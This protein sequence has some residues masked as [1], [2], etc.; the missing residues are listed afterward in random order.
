MSWIENV[1]IACRWIETL[2]WNQVSSFSSA[3]RSRKYQTTSLVDPRRD[4]AIGHRLGDDRVGDPLQRRIGSHFRRN[5]RPQP[6]DRQPLV[7]DEAP[8]VF[9]AQHA[10]QFVAVAGGQ[11][12]GQRKFGRHV[13]RDRGRIARLHDVGDR[14]PLVLLRL[15]IPRRLEIADR[16]AR[17]RQPLDT[18]LAAAIVKDQHRAPTRVQPGAGQH[19]ARDGV[20]VILARDQDPHRHLV[21]AHQHRDQRVE[22]LLQP[23]VLHLRALLQRQD[24]RHVGRHVLRKRTARRR[25]HRQQ[26]QREFRP[27]A[28]THMDIPP[29]R[30][31]DRFRRACL[32]PASG[33]TGNIPMEEYPSSQ[34]SLH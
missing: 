11:P 29:M 20:F 12:V 28:C 13:Q 22:P 1:S 19:R 24:A 14:L 6:V 5:A 21:A 26:P 31:G 30:A 17:H 27:T 3:T 10:R 33:F 16:I 15:G 32:L 34:T 9:V 8:C 23:A 7:A 25:R 18:R 4:D 2:G